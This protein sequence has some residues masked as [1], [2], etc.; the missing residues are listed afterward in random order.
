MRSTTNQKNARPPSNSKVN[1][2]ILAN[3][4]QFSSLGSFGVTPTSSSAILSAH[5]HRLTANDS[6][7]QMGPL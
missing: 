5:P 3:Q 6:H 1:Q 7:L 2:A 4:M